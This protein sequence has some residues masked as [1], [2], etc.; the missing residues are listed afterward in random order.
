MVKQL[1]TRFA[2]ASLLGVSLGGC[3]VYLPMQCAA[4]ALYDK[5]QVEL[6]GSAYFNKRLNGAINYS[7]VRHLLVRAALDGK[8]DAD[9]STY[10]RS[11][12]YELAVGT[13]WPLGEQVVLGAL[14]GAGQARSQV[15]YR[16][17]ETP[18]P[19]QYEYDAHYN[20]L[21]GEVYGTWQIG[22]TMQ[23]GAAYRLTH[24]RFTSLTNLGR[25]LSLTSMLRSEPMFFLRSTFGFRP[26]GERLAYVQAGVGGSAL[27]R[28]WPGQLGGPESNLLDSNTYL[29]IGL[30]FFPSMLWRH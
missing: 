2:G 1:L 14:V 15:R 6:A 16:P 28:A 9:D 19:E 12:Q 21:V 20:K 4:P 30:G 5:G 24:V 3:A 13:Y 10:T 23:F 8:A 25:P 18:S 26:G 29:T 7:P 17:I 27:L 11:R 22:P